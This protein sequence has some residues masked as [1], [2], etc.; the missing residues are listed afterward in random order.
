MNLQILFAQYSHLIQQKALVE[1]HFTGG[2][3]I[4]EHFKSSDEIWR[5]NS[6]SI[7]LAL[8]VCFHV[9]SWHWKMSSVK[10]SFGQCQLILLQLFR[11]GQTVLILSYQQLLCGHCWRCLIFY[12]KHN[13]VRLC[14]GSLSSKKNF[15]GIAQR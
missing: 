8:K 9:Y 10:I 12:Q 6:E 15:S 13:P 1:V 11:L 4:N 7:T 2:N 5:E 3:L 14:A